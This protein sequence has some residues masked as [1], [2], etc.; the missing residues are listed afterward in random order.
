MYSIQLGARQVVRLVYKMHLD[1]KK[2]GAGP[3]FG[4]LGILQEA[5]ILDIPKGN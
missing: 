4:C 2:G 3:I 1:W 5:L